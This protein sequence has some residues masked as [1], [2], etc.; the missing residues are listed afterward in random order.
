MS[1]PVNIN[2]VLHGHCVE[3]ERLELKRDLNPEAILHTLCAFA[4]DFHNLGGGYVFI[5]IEENNGRPVL[6]P[7]GIATNRLDGMQKEILE[8]GYRLRP[9][10][11]PV[12]VPYVIEGRSVLALWAPGGQNRPYKAPVSM[13]RDNNREY[14]YYIRKGSS[15]VRAAHE[16]E[17]ELIGLAA[18]VPFDDR[19]CHH[20]DLSDLHLPLI[21]DYLK[22]IGSELYHDVDRLDLIRLCRQMQI[23]EGPDETVKP[24]NVGLLFFHD[25][26]D[27]F[28]PQTQID[29]VQFPDGP[30]ADIFK[31]KIFRGPLGRMLKDALVYLQSILIEEIVV[32]HPG[33]AEAERFFNYP[34]EAMEE[35]LV[36]AVYHRSYEIREP[37]EVRILP[38][39]VTITSFPGP[40]RSISLADLHSG[41]F[42]S[43]RYRNRRIGEF[44]KELSLAEGR[45]TGIPKILRVMAENGSASPQF[46]TDENRSYFICHFSIHPMASLRGVGGVTE[47]VAPEVTPEVAPEVLRLLGVLHGAMDR[48][49]LQKALALKAEKNFRL[50]YLRPALDSGFIE[51][52][53]PDKPRSSKQEYRLTDKG[54]KLI[55]TDKG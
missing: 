2:D 41:S 20:A 17:V 13:S 51:M 30:G 10:Y 23:V 53:I 54:R 36:N 15:T 28:F 33:R 19:I 47:Q 39:R 34:F 21:R 31:E 12:M 37:I 49:A 45:G 3:W 32:K 42:I 9:H 8:M 55:E 27:R 52:T 44:L 16:E 40:D 26:P 38:D 1:L 18:Q 7:S 6:P 50:R 14:A 22:D 24:R 11:H 48:Q 46:E 4:N 5:G 29:I 35:A 25:R 43:R